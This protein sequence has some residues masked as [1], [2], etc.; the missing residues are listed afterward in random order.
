MDQ[1]A[2]SERA[3]ANT[4]TYPPPVLVAVQFHCS[5]DKMTRDFSVYNS[6]Y[7]FPGCPS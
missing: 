6:L 2:T 5:Y 1:L 3:G 7:V 4:T